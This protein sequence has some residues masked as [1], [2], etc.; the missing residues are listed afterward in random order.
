LR[1]RVCEF[2]RSTAPDEAGIRGRCKSGGANL[3][4]PVPQAALF[5]AVEV[6]GGDGARRSLRPLSD[7]SSQRIASRK[8]GANTA[9]HWTKGQV[10]VSRRDNF[11]HRELAVVSLSTTEEL[12]M[13]SNN[14]GTAVELKSARKT[15]RRAL[16]AGGILA[17]AWW[18]TGAAPLSAEVTNSAPQFTVN[19]IGKGDRL[20]MPRTPAVRH[21][22]HHL[23]G[24]LEAD[25]PSNWHWS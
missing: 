9:R 7:R 3:A 5:A 2:Q 11:C 10:A 14:L 21:R 1:A 19:R 4:K 15:Q 25:F 17:L 16:A 20:P 18:I 12:A 6:A 8:S 24:L 13:R 23:S 22:K